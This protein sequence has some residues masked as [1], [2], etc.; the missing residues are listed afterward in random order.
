MRRPGLRSDPVASLERQQSH[1]IT[2]IAKNKRS[3]SVIE[4]QGSVSGKAF[5][6]FTLSCLFRTLGCSVR[7]ALC[8]TTCLLM[9][10]GLLQLSRPPLHLDLLEQLLRTGC[11][12]VAGRLSTLDEA[13]RRHVSELLRP[14]AGGAVN[15]TLLSE[16]LC[17]ALA[18]QMDNVV[19]CFG[20]IF[21]SICRA[22]PDFEEV[23]KRLLHPS[24]KNEARNTVITIRAPYSGLYFPLKV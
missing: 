19:T 5:L 11:H 20:L 22:G 21:E 16:G 18:L 1:T 9:P 7:S 12:L 4:E 13:Q 14:P 23:R 8:Q 2:V 3:Q 10:S 17:L 15:E 6:G 24:S